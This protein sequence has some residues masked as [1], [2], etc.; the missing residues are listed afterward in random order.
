M[1][2]DNSAK[3]SGPPS[4]PLSGVRVLDMTAVLMGPYCT[5]ILS[6]LGAD[7]IKI[8]SPEG[9]ITRQI[10]PGLRDGNSGLY[11]TLNRGKRSVLLDL[12]RD[13]AKAAV[14]K[15]VET[16][17]V[18][19]HSVRA[20]AMKRL[21][22]TYDTLS[23][24]NPGLVYA[25]LYGFGLGGC[26]AG[27]PAYDDV[28]QGMTGVP[29]LEAQAAGEPRYL[30]N[31]MADKVSGLSAAY[32]IMAALFAHAKTGVGQEVSISMF[33]TMSAFMLTEHMTGA[34]FS[35]P[36]SEPVYQRIVAKERKPFKTKDG[37]VGATIY[38]NKHWHRFTDIVGQPGL[39]GDARFQDIP[40]RLK[41]VSAYY[42]LLQTFTLQRTTEAW[43][44]AL[45][46]AEIP[47]ARINS[48]A[49]LLTD[50]HLEQVG[51][52]KTLEH[53]IDGTLKFPG[54]PIEFSKTPAEIQSGP[55]ELGEHTASVLS[56]FGFSEEEISSLGVG[57]G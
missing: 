15:M 4:G 42:E 2:A 40:S 8:E 55:P 37:Y 5:Q 7:V 41:N 56:E 46:E 9:D 10:G 38:N 50:P 47:A 11:Y 36:I 16:C 54:P 17:D 12:K 23:A 20:P 39:R 14:L 57:E 26:Y 1:N 48:T 32:A 44:E 6:D 51:F 19:V 18:F 31:V 45:N 22:L 49:D 27:Q 35:P 33:E 21:G 30:A 52:F 34:V 29:H 24:V 25:N 43:L 3:P 53:P 28:I 13:D